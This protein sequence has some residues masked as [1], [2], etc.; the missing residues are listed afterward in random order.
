VQDVNL[1]L[2]LALVLIHAEADG[3]EHKHTTD[4]KQQIALKGLTP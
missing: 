3:K 4:A 2:L 1:V